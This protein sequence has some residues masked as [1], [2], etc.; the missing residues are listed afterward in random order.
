[1]LIAYKTEINPTNEQ[2][3]KINRT[4][5]VVRFVENKYLAHNIEV[6][7]NG[8]S[9][10]GYM[11]YSKWLNNTFV[12]MHP[13]FSWIKDV[14][15]KAIK[16]GLQNVHTAFTKFF[17]GESDFPQFKKKRNQDVSMYFVKN[18]AKTIIQVER[19]RMKVPTLGWVKLK[20]KGYIPTHSPSAIVKSGTISQKA[21]RYFVSVLVEV[22]DTKS[23]LNLDNEGLGADLDI[24]ETAIR[25]D[26]VTHKNISK[27]A[28]VRKL[29]RKLKKEQR[30]LSRKY[31]AEKL[32]IKNKEIKKGEA[33]RRNIQKQVLKVQRIHYSL[34]NLR[35]DFQ[36][37]IVADIAKTKPSNVAIE[38][39]NIKGI[40]KNKH[41]SKAVAQQKLYGLRTKLEW[42]AK[43]GYFELRMVD[44]WYPSSKLCHNCGEKKVDLKLS[45][46]TYQC[47]HCGYTAD[48][49][50][51]A[52]LNLR[53]AKEYTVLALL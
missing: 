12:P 28:K 21:D 24:K 43:Q 50:F 14:Y 33:T 41:L 48:R 36:N 30:K 25:S 9:F 11:D 19:H 34:T 49:D 45:D 20:E 38:D 37:K 1:M 6:Y 29:E 26:R 52:S 7:E 39:L 27:S 51:N 23:E 8:G 17:K 13:E 3:T 2:K 40:M 31:E 32:R 15:A 5:G 16:R 44:R 47:E 22:P 10:V 35:N 53:D 46:R 42:K 4:V 18:D